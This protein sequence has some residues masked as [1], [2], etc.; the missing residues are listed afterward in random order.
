[1]PWAVMDE[2]CLL[3]YLMLQ[4]SEIEWVIDLIAVVKLVLKAYYFFFLFFRSAEQL[5]S[6]HKEKKVSEYTNHKM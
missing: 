3:N 5:E 4:I 1:M 6:E 2:R